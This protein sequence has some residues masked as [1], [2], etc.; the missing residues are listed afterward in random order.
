MIK[1]IWL[2]DSVYNIIITNLT[3]NLKNM[4]AKFFFNDKSVF[5]ICIE[6]CAYEI[7]IIKQKKNACWNYF[8]AVVIYIY[9]YTNTY[10]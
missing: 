10:I 3:L 8:I 7:Y 5:E 2:C 6:T 4:F 9:I 1:Q